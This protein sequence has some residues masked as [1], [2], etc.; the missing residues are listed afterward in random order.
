M[1]KVERVSNNPLISPRQGEKLEALGTFNPSIVKESDLY[2]LLYRAQ[3]EPMD[4]AGEHMSVSSIWYAQSRDGLA[5]SEQTQFIK[6]EESWERY[7]CEDPRVTK[8]GDKYYIFYTAL[9]HYPFE[10][11]GI[12]IGL[13]ITRDFKTI[14][15][16]HLV[17]RFNSKAMALF[18]EKI[19]GKYVGIL[20]VDTDRPPAKIALAFFDREEDMWSED[21]WKAWYESLNDHVIPLL[22]TPKDHLEVGAAPVRT[23]KGWLLIYSYIKNYLSNEKHFGVEGVL[24]DA[25]NPA[26]VIGRTEDSLM[27]PEKAYELKGQVENIVFPSGALLKGKELYIYYG[28]A[29]TSSC[30]AY[31]DIEE[32][33]KEML[34]KHEKKPIFCFGGC[35]IQGFKRS[36]QNPIIAPRPEFAWEAKG[37]LNPAV[38]YEK[39]KFHIV[40]RAMSS[41]DTS[42]FGYASS[43]DGVHIDERLSNPI[44]VPRA[45]FEQKKRFGNSGVE[46]PRLTKMGDRFYI[47]YTAYDGYVPRVAFSY[48]SVEDFLAHR[49]NW[50]EPVVITP[51]GIDDKDSCLL[52]KK[53]NNRYV[54]FHRLDNY[55][56]INLVENLDFKENE[57]LSDMGYMIKPRKEYW[58][59]KKFGIASPPIETKYGWILFFH[60][61]TKQDSIYKVE[62]LLLDL[63]DPTKVIGETGA[64]LL[65]PCTE[66]EI[67]GAVNNV[68]FPCGSVLLN[69][70]VYLYYG[71]GDAV[72]GVAKMSLHDLFKRFG[73]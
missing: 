14:E 39:G 13:A 67:K 56:R 10:A 21:Y 29:D 1:I 11:N 42:T 59:N 9:S 12:K 34:K 25:N 54:I 62:A 51:P 27:F 17:T 64:T 30:A 68:V 2:H 31:C 33:E 3:S 24:L 53:I 22:R 8:V 69:D 61:V 7:G 6:P 38:V 47:F 63:K 23:Q 58:D 26:K 60:R 50:K 32:L 16:K 18:P 40:Y 44:Y 52:S 66:Y 5:F 43:K 15:S 45:S 4:H 71:G 20:T 19:N 57:Y 55:I 46:D 28:A 70:E 41:D 35:S 37:T 65:E 49:W 72:V 48:I 73:M 36:D